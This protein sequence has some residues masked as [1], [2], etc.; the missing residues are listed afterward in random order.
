MQE[1]FFIINQIRKSG[2][3]G[4]DTSLSILVYYKEFVLATLALITVKK[5]LKTI[6]LFKILIV[7][8]I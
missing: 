3:I 5:L 7:Y 4:K 8:T 6:D 2:K 1:K